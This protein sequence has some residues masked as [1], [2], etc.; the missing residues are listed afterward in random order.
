MLDDALHRVLG[1]Y[2]YGE[3][4][5][6]RYEGERRLEVHR[7]VRE[8]RIGDFYVLLSDERAIGERLRE[9]VLQHASSVVTEWFHSVRDQAL[10]QEAAGWLAEIRAWWLLIRAYISFGFQGADWIHSA[11]D[12]VERSYRPFVELKWA[13]VVAA[14]H[15]ALLDAVAPRHGYDWSSNTVD[16][17]A[18]VRDALAAV[19]FAELRGTVGSAVARPHQVL[20]GFLAEAAGEARGQYERGELL[21]SQCPDVLAAVGE[22]VCLLEDCY[23]EDFFI[24]ALQNGDPRI[25]TACEWTVGQT[26]ILMPEEEIVWFF[27]DEPSPPDTGWLDSVDMWMDERVVDAIITGKVPFPAPPPEPGSIERGDDPLTRL[28]DRWDPRRG[29]NGHQIDERIPDDPVVRAYLGWGEAPEYLINRAILL[30]DWYSLNAHLISAARAA[31]DMGAAERAAL[32][33]VAVKHLPRLRDIAQVWKALG[34]DR[35]TLS[36]VSI[37]RPSFREILAAALHRKA[38]ALSAQEPA[39]IKSRP[40]ASARREKMV[41]DTPVKRRRRELT[42]M[43]LLTTLWPERSLRAAGFLPASDKNH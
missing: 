39:K 18:A 13:D 2:D 25:P 19:W 7:I 6:Q 35:A 29:G 10:P 20:W 9:A 31:S 21:L 42:P 17:E 4:I 11:V 36:T 32:M 23:G 24:A 3:I 34:G 8:S 22:L 12:R 27:E 26:L 14:E 43:E 5:D 41:K 40:A 16:R 30:K 15:E 37:S 28:R 1:D 33:V 38:A